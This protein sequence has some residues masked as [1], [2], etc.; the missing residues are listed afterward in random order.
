M[1]TVTVMLKAKNSLSGELATPSIAIIWLVDR[2][3]SKLVAT[4]EL[5]SWS[6]HTVIMS[7]LHSTPPYVVVDLI[8]GEPFMW[9]DT[10]VAPLSW[11]LDLSALVLTVG[12][13]V[14]AFEGAGV[15]CT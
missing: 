7:S 11:S 9:H 14:G 2:P 12:C 3:F 5:R 13:G 15:G 1:I 6:A 4:P 10:I 8:Q